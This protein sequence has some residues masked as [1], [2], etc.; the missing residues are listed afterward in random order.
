M[1]V[2]GFLRDSMALECILPTL[3]VLEGLEELL[4]EVVLQGQ[5]S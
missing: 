5:V 1:V 4:A 2:S 3:I